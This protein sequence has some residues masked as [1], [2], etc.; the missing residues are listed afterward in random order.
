MGSTIQWQHCPSHG[1]NPLDLQRSTNKK[2]LPAITPP[3]ETT[4][5]QARL[6]VAGRCIWHC[7][8]HELPATSWDAGLSCR[9]SLKN[10]RRSITV[11]LI[12]TYIKTTSIKGYPVDTRW[13]NR[14]IWRFAHKSQPNPGLHTAHLSSV[15]HV[16]L[17]APPH[18]RLIVWTWQDQPEGRH[19]H[20]MSAE[21]EIDRIF[22]ANLHIYIHVVT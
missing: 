12:K 7:T 2:N 1:K 10:T 20:I 4:N 19:I 11:S 15:S 13:F 3:L 21:M 14:C 18:Q 6:M 22:S 17:L 16:L 5:S 9:I 8:S